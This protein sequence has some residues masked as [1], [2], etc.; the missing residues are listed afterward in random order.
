MNLRNPWLRTA[1]YSF[2]AI[3]I[4]IGAVVLWQWRLV[5]AIA[6]NSDVIFEGAEWAE[7]VK[8]PEGVRD[9]IAAHP[10]TV[11][12]ASFEAGHE[13]DGL[14][15]HAG[16]P[17]SL[18]STVKI[19]ALSAYARAVEEGAVD[20]DERLPLSAW[21]AFYLPATDG[22]A[23]PAALQDLEARKAIEN[24]TVALREIVRAMIQYSDNAAT[25]AVLFRLTQTRID[26]EPAA[27]GLPAEE[28]PF[29]ISGAMILA[30][31]P[32]EGTLPREWIAQT[33]AK[34]RAHI[35]EEAWRHAAKLRDD[36]VWRQGLLAQM[37]EE[38]IG[39][40]MRE[41][42]AYAKELVPRG[43]AL[44]YAKLMEQV[45]TAPASSRRAYVMA[46]MLE[47]PMRRG[48]RIS[49]DFERFGTKGGSLLGVLTS[50]TY[51]TPNG[52]RPRVLALFFEDLPVAVFAQLSKTYAQQDFERKLLEEESFLAETRRALAATTEDGGTP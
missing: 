18:A 14:F 50:A 12:I 10:G 30:R 51:A 48:G 17:R 20:P 34:G 29:P 41:Q 9:Y 22:G 46:D 3:C 37:G 21:E 47:W 25:D 49:K 11:S 42:L 27:L 6:E 52:E 43:S 44:G 40:N 16:T 24:E 31:S 33:S 28:A 1:L 45:V 7:R 39:L 15:L 5:A 19:L 23:H 35:R 32:P 4:A 38:G 26:A 2:G 36:V 8:T 13:A